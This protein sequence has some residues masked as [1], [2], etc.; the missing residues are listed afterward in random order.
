MLK[1]H[2]AASRQENLEFSEMDVFSSMDYLTEET[3][4]SE[5]FEELNEINTAAGDEM[6]EEIKTNLLTMSDHIIID[7]MS[8]LPVPSRLNMG[9][10][11]KRFNEILKLNPNRFSFTLKL[12]FIQDEIP[13]FDRMYRTV[14]IL[15]LDTP[16]EDSQRLEKVIET[17]KTIGFHV[18]DVRFTKCKLSYK[19]MSA[20]LAFMPN[21]KNLVIETTLLDPI[22]V[23]DW[24]ELPSLKKVK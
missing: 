22:D 13:E 1:Q 10:T 2:G 12:D 19:L 15:N 24:P 11:C 14:K 3:T 18:Q 21:I 8:F 16:A 9:L 7:I 23:C 5:F 4:R 6:E 20:I 17:F